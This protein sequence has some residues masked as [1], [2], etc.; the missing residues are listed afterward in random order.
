MNR[1]LKKSLNIIFGTTITFLTFSFINL[2]KVEAVNIDKFAGGKGTSD[3]PYIIDDAAGLIELGANWC[4]SR[5]RNTYFKID[6]GSKILDLERRRIIPI[7]SFLDGTD[8]ASVYENAFYGHFDGN[9][10]EITNGEINSNGLSAGLFG[11]TN[12]AKI[13]NVGIGE[14]ISF[15]V[16]GKV[17]GSEIAPV[18]GIVGSAWNTEITNVWN[19]GYL[20]TEHSSAGGIAGRLLSGSSITNAY[21]AGSV[22]AKVD[23]DNKSFVGGIVGYMSNSTIQ[24][25][26]NYSSSLSGT[27]D[28]E[29]MGLL[30]GWIAD[31]NNT[32][33]NAYTL[34]ENTNLNGW[35]HADDNSLTDENVAGYARSELTNQE[36]F[37]GF[38]FENVWE[39]GDE[40]PILRN[41][42]KESVHTPGTVSDG[43]TIKYNGEVK[44]IENFLYNDGR[45]YVNLYEFC[46]KS[47]ICSVSNNKK[48]KDIY[49]IDKNIEVTGDK[50][51]S[52]VSGN[53]RYTY[54]VMHTEG[55]MI[56]YPY[57]MIGNRTIQDN[58]TNQTADVPSCPS[59]IEEYKCDEEHFYVPIRF[60]SQSLGLRVEWDGENNTVN[61]KNNFVETFLSKYDV[62]TTTTRDCNNSSCIVE[63]DGIYT[64]VREGRTYYLN[65]IDKETNKLMD[66][67]KLYSFYDSSIKS[68]GNDNPSY[69]K[70]FYTLNKN[71]IVVSNKED[72]ENIDT[73]KNQKSQ[74]IAQI[75]VYEIKTTDQDYQ[76]SDYNAGGYPIVINNVFR[77]NDC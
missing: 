5:Y 17:P 62:V 39:M 61:I 11:A 37:Y 56:F 46:S 67:Y 34:K 13:A 69:T 10:T 20:Y 18:G 12:G 35:G 2:N 51:I 32:I 66:Y 74:N 59:D 22:S 43:M 40:Y 27:G 26:A 4:G 31:G 6:T 15:R 7:C 65:V 57:I 28:S 72:D 21:N 1:I 49:Y 54:R 53:T 70:G 41:T 30:V 55:E 42:Y 45:T 52:D 73:N 23:A 9:N 64:D 25:V 38:D 19:K 29:S 77:C 14:N 33:K 47:E 60:L 68:G 48:D 44:N 24:N 75:V 8:E 16:N 36:N 3:D 50:I 63:K 71:T 76:E 58:A